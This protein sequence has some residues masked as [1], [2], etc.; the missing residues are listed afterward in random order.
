MEESALPE[1]IRCPLENIILK[2]KLLDMGPPYAVLA[3]ALDTPNL[4]DI[5]NTILVLKELGALQ[6]TSDGII[7]VHDGDLTFMGRVMA[8]LPV[9]VR[10]SRLIVLG[11]CFGVLEECVIMGKYI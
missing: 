11:F 5:A 6:R 3:L 8:N 10:V 9:D 4:S 2:T 1:L 7:S